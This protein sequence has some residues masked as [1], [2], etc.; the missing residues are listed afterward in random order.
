MTRGL[1]IFMLCALPRLL[2]L[3]LS[4]PP[5]LTFYWLYASNLLEHET[6][7]AHGIPDT[8][9]E[10]L[11]PLFLAAARQVSGDRLAVVLGAQVAFAAVGGVFLYRLTL[12]LSDDS[13][14]AWMATLFYALDP[15]IVRQSV[16]LME[17]A[18]VTTL[19]IG[20]ASSA[21]RPLIAGGLVGA[22]VLTRFSL[23]PLLV[24]VPLVLWRHPGKHAVVTFLTSLCVLTPWLVRN[25]N[26]DGSIG[27]SRGLVNLAV[28]LTDAADQL[29][30]QHNNDRLLVLLEGKNDD[31]L[32]ASAIAFIRENPWQVVKMKARNFLHVFNPHL[33]PYDHEPNSAVL[34]DADGHYSIEGTTPRSTATR[35][36]HGLW[37]AALLALAITGVWLRGVRRED[38]VLWAVVVSITIVCTAFFPTTRLT[39]PMVFAWMIWA[40]LAIVLLAR[41]RL[42]LR[43]S[44]R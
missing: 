23:A 12:S 7:G 15:Y 37:R 35:W 43:W 20:V 5:E 25:Y 32:R 38:G 24:F 3:W 34:R 13:R 2:F 41:N 33:L 14:V 36:I 19:L 11:Y 29:L 22:V 26:V 4:P 40:A 28:S 18:F 42:R 39:T 44:Q 10:P 8:Y 17:V 6:F 1:G 21:G 16:S 31:A 30:P 27:G 9:V